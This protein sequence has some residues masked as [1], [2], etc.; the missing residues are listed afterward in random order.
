MQVSRQEVVAPGSDGQLLSLA[1][2]GDFGAFE[3]LV[4]KVER[5]LAEYAHRLGAPPATI[6]ACLEATVDR[7]EDHLD[8]L[9]LPD[10]FGIWIFRVA[11][12]AI[13]KAAP[14]ATDADSRLGFE[15]DPDLD[16]DS[17][18]ESI[19]QRIA[20]RVQAALLSLPLPHREA[21]V[22]KI[23]HGLSFPDIARITGSPPESIHYWI[24]ISLAQLSKRF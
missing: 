15:S 1:S 10:R 16:V 6:D 24:Q 4:R 22:L 9:P 14:P 2:G 20:P 13:V 17:S 11:R 3:R 7:L 19:R 23:F 21:T 5:P 12:A 18:P 8:R